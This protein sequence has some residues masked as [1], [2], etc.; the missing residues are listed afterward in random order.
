MP[1]RKVSHPCISSKQIVPTVFSAGIHAAN[2][3]SLTSVTDEEVEQEEQETKEEQ[4]KQENK[5]Q[6]E[7]ANDA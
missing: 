5:E 1:Y 4:E 7:R 3:F 2:R 6:E